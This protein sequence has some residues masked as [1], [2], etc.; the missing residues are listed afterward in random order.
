[1]SEHT[2]SAKSGVPKP[3]LCETALVPSWRLAQETAKKREALQRVAELER[4][5]AELEAAL[6]SKRDE[7]VFRR[8][9]R[10]LPDLTNSD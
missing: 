9:P 1:M 10:V 5:V 7:F 4:R 2:S 8:K 6:K 3:I